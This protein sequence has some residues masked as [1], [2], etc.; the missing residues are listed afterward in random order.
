M[1]FFIETA[2]F[3]HLIASEKGCRLND[4]VP[5]MHQLPNIWRR[6]IVVADM[7]SLCVQ[8]ACIAVNKRG[9]RVLLK[10]R[11]RGGNS[12]GFQH[13]IG[14]NP[15]NNL[16]YSHGETFV[17]R[18]GLT[19][20]ALGNPSHPL[21]KFAQNGNS[22]ICRPAIDDKVFDVRVV[23]CEDTLNSC[24]NEPSLIVGRR[25]DRND[26]P[27]YFHCAQRHAIHSF[28]EKSIWLYRH[29][30]RSSSDSF[31]GWSTIP[32]SHACVEI[33]QQDKATRPCFAVEI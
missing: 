1:Q 25:N 21:S 8:F 2:D 26:R 27:R 3:F 18:M 5:S 24:A 4:I 17:N 15:G 11:N 6:R 9:A 33:A 20:I 19:A 32:R 22:M 28:S 16:A 13:V 12:A 10:S 31:P 30:P 7:L 23:L 29:K 14:I